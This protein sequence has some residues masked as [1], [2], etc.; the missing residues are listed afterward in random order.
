MRY[1]VTHFQGEYIIAFDPIAAATARLPYVVLGGY[2]TRRAACDAS[3]LLL[4][5]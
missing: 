3:E 4:G 2:T 1:Y 5:E